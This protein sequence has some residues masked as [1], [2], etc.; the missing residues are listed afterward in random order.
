MTE[1]LNRT[2]LNF[3]SLSG[4]DATD[5]QYSYAPQ[6]CPIE[7]GTANIAEVEAMDIAIVLHTFITENVVGVHTYRY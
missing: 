7:D 2:I 5:D 4:V 6:I 1:R 3:A